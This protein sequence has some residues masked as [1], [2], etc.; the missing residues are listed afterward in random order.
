MR[1][2]II[3][4]L[5]ILL[6]AGSLLFLYPSFANA[7]E[8]RDATTQLTS[9]CQIVPV[10]NGLKGCGICDFFALVSNI[11]GFI[12]FRLAPPVAGI[13]IIFAGALFLMSGGSEERI[14][15]AKKIFINV[16]IGLVFIYASVLIVNSIIVVIG[17]SVQ[18]FNPTSW[19]TFQCTSN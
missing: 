16:V 13:L 6:I 18:G 5:P 4:I 8:C 3:K 19:R 9:N 11:F 2:K 1:K 10:C 15:Q 17:K 12:A 7:L 14:G